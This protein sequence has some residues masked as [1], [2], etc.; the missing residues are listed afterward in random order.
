MLAKLNN[1]FCPFPW[2]DDK[3]RQRVMS[4]NNF[5]EADILYHGLPPL[6]ATLSPP[7]KPILTH[8][9]S[10][11]LASSDRLLFISHLL[12]HPTTREWRLVQVAFADSTALSPLCLQDG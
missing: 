5:E 11:I 1:E 10:S 8:L 7:A 9:V 6:L 3:E 12:G 4:R 2:I